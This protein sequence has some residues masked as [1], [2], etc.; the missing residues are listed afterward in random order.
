MKSNPWDPDINWSI[1][2]LTSRIA[3]T[4][5]KLDEIQN[6]EP[7]ESELTNYVR[8]HIVNMCLNNI[9]HYMKIRSEKMKS[10]IQ[11]KKER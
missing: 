2:K 4:Q 3:E 5:K 10:L 1:D 9:Q 11:Q 6:L 8:V 7:S